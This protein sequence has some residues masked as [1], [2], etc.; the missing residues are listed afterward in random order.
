M[1]WVCRAGKNGSDFGDVKKYGDIFLAWEG[2]RLNLESFSSRDSFK[3]LVIKEKNPSARTSISNWAGQLYSFCQEMTRGDYVLVP[4][5][6]SHEYLLTIVEGEYRYDT[7]R[8]YPH[9]R[10]I[11]TVCDGILRSQFTQSTQ[12]SLGAF[13]TVFKVKQEEE[14][15]RVAQ[16]ISHGG[17]L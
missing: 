9:V 1:M 5:N 15:L 11:K 4:Y 12:Y 16:L 8:K 10:K 17:R 2:F 3:E 14:I 13:R 7:S 6:K